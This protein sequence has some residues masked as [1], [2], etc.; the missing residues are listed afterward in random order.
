M[1][2]K[3]LL[4]C[5]AILIVIIIVAIGLIFNSRED[6]VVEVVETTLSYEDELKIILDNIVLDYIQIEYKSET[7]EGKINEAIDELQLYKTKLENIYN[8]YSEDYKED[9]NNFVSN[10][11]T[12]VDEIIGKYHNDMEIIQLWN[13]R[14]EEYPVATQ[15]WLSMK[16]QGW[17]DEVCAGIMGNIMTECGGQSLNIRWNAYSSSGNYYGICQW[18]AYYYPTVQ[19]ASLDEQLGF[20]YNT[21]QNA[22]KTFGFCY[23]NGFTYQDF[24]HMIDCRD[25][26]LAFAKIYER[27][28]SA[29]Y[30]IRQR[31]AQ[32]A[33]NYF[34][35]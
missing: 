33:Y 3:V 32:K 2:K 31:N 16:E 23:K 18:S 30:G 1:N 15:I 26:A 14:A 6:N 34:C 22:F 9:I 28:G 8:D 11:I 10:E 29:S 5:V 7:D 27:C 13:K 12:R 20:L 24:L 19:G 21:I 35:N 17:S 4:V 25:V